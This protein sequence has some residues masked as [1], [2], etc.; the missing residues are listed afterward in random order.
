MIMRP[1]SSEAIEE[2]SLE[3]PRPRLQGRG[4]KN[5]GSRD[6]RTIPPGERTLGDKVCAF[7]ETYCHIPE[8]RRV[9][10]PLMLEA[11]ERAW[12][13]DTFDNPAGTRRSILSMARKNGKTSIIACIVL[14]FLVGPLARPN[15]QLAS[16]ARSRDQAALVYSLMKKMIGFSPVLNSRIKLVDSKK[17]AFGMTTGTEYRAISAEA[18]TAFGMSPY[19]VI[20][21]EAGQV[22]GAV[23][24][25]TEAL[26]T[27][28]GAYDD[29]IV[30]V[31][32]TQA[33]SD[34]A[35]LSQWI[36][37]ALSDRDPT[38]V[39]HLYEAGKEAGLEDVEE[40]LKANPG[41]DVIRSRRDLMKQ[42]EEARRLPSKENSVRNLLMN[43]RVQM[44][45][46]FLSQQIW[47]DCDAELDLALFT[48]G[49]PVYAGLDL[50]STTDLTAL[51]LAVEDDDSV[52]H[53][54]PIVWT[55]SEGLGD[56]GM[57]DRAPY[58]DWHKDGLLTTIPGKVIDP[59][60]M[61]PVIAETVESMNIVR[62]NFDRWRIKSFK[63]ACEEIGLELMLEEC[64]QGYRDMSPAIDYFEARALQRKLA[65]G[66]NPL[67]RWAMGN[68]VI[69]RDPA[70]NR[71][72]D[73]SRSFSRVDPVV[74]AAMA[75]KGLDADAEFTPDAADM[76][77]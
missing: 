41:I 32:S 39:C 2:Q 67:L 42:I 20:L 60:A 46:P 45:A 5:D 14:C 69:T 1:S 37:D 12:I 25:F 70:S 21:D 47:D 31:I 63:A 75:I 73:K 76:I 58:V 17:Q 16:G 13:Y 54:W 52:A 11:F 28:Q 74:A 53:L 62:T 22:G 71:K 61:V 43:Q 77:G 30:L 15:A 23:D 34:G 49:R 51:V 7:V 68:T 8:G 19:V 33:A 48:S 57:R 38:L 29:G 55:P 66:G 50:S 59:R 24:D 72:I 35:M 36:D 6:W 64:G 10:D 9:G 40:I 18:S 26:T 44:S 4:L 65:H 3:I 27:A 56:R